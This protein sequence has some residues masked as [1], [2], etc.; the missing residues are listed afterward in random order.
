MA[1]I[2]ITPETLTVRF[3]TSERVLGLVRDITVPRSAVGDVTVEADAL[4]AVRGLRAPGLGLPGLRKVGTWRGFGGAPRRTAV[5][6]GKG[7]PAVRIALLGQRWDELVIGADD[8][9]ELA[10]RLGAPVDG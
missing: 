5:S 8:A 10:A 7:Q 2:E 1:S 3:S 9:T 4:A 6:V